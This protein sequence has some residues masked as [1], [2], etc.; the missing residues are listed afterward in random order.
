[1]H[2]SKCSEAR[3]PWTIMQYEDA[4]SPPARLDFQPQAT[5]MEVAHITTH[6][7]VYFIPRRKLIFFGFSHRS[8]S[9]HGH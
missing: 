9:N 4:V 5:R 1:V 2:R 8:S 6:N 7:A 3:L